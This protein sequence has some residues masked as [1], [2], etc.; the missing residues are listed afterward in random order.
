M[1]KLTWQPAASVILSFLAKVSDYLT[2]GVGIRLRLGVG[3]GG[4]FG[5][6]IWINQIG[7]AIRTIRRKIQGSKAIPNIYAMII[8]I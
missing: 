4:E 8:P 2:R 6:T 7:E 3:G 5:S 1:L